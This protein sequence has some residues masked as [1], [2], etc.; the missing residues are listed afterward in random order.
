VLREDSITI[1]GPGEKKI[2]R[3]TH[4]QLETRE[5]DSNGRS[6]TTTPEDY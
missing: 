4:V 6:T 2:E 1:D 3:N 5:N